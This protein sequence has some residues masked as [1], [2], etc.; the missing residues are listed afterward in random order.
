VVGAGY[1]LCREERSWIVPAVLLSLIAGVWSWR[2]RVRAISLRSWAAL[3]VVLLASGLVGYVGV[4]YVVQRN[5]QVYGA[6]VVSDIADGQLARAY[7][8]W[9]SVEAGTRRR[10][11]PITVAMRKAAYA[12]SPAA[13][14]LRPALE[15]SAKHWAVCKSEACDYLGAF[16]I[17]AL[18]E[19]ISSAGH[20]HSEVELQRFS[21]TL[22]DQIQAGCDTHRLTCGARGISLSPPIR[23]S[24]IGPI[25]SSAADATGYLL[26]FDAA[27]PDR[28]TGSYGV[29]WTWAQATK[30]IPEA[31]NEAVFQAEERS[32]MTRQRPV[33]LLQ[34]TYRVLAYPVAVVAF[35]GLLWELVRPRRSLGR[36]LAI[37]LIAVVVA[38]L[39]RIAVV[40][41][42]DSLSYAAARN[43]QYVI[44]ATDLFILMG[45]VGTWLFG[46]H[47]ADLL[48]TRRHP[49]T[50][51]TEV[52]A[53]GPSESAPNEGD[54]DGSGAA[55]VEIAGPA[56]AGR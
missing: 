45:A 5:R 53:S 1:Y 42:V 10:H 29:G 16:F 14:E 41:L 4:N 15:G 52:D 3:L 25:L 11:Y 48:A 32:A 2:Q 35:L 51:A 8:I 28:G 40:A 7:S 24:D 31:R 9:Q 13:A 6:G 18:R 33:S 37:A 20:L 12:V 43:E 49:S 19:A 50:P 44:P 22:A 55:S 54:E 26:S 23:G 17:W 30:V 56:E 27:T 38:L 46:R 36:A 39:A 47:F 34:T 21:R